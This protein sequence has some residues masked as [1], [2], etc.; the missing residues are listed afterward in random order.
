MFHSRTTD[1]AHKA[2]LSKNTHKPF[3]LLVRLVWRC[4]EHGA[5][6]QLTILEPLS[7]IWQNICC[8]SEL[9]TI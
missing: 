5:L 8:Q 2:A 4:E 9:L 3:R 7:Q 1:A 6:D